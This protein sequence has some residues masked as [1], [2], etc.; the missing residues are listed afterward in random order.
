MGAADTAPTQRSAQ[1]AARVSP[2]V[3]WELLQPCNQIV[4]FAW[5]NNALK[6]LMLLL[7]STTIAVAGSNVTTGL[8]KR[9]S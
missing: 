8:M 6:P 9:N 2:A 5:Q 7:L 4:L 1:Y 3:Q